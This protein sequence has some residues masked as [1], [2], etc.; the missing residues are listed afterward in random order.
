MRYTAEESALLQTLA[1]Q[2]SVAIKNGYLYRES[3][4]KSIIEEELA[5]A[6]RIQ[7]Q[8]LPQSLPSTPKLDLAALNV[9]T[10]EV[11][12]DYYDVV[13]LGNGEYLVVIADVAGKGVPAALL[14][15]MV[16]ASIRTQAQDRRPMGEL[17]CRLNRLVYDATPEDRFATCVLAHIGGDDPMLF[18]NAGHNFP[19]VLPAAGGWRY[20]EEGGIPLGVAP[21]FAYLE[22]SARLQDGDSLLLYTDGITDA[23]NLDG[24]DYGEERL[25]SLA[26]R[27]P[28]DYT[29][30]QIVQAVA[31][32]VSQFTGGAEQAD[33]ITLVALKTR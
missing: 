27:L 4:A 33:D 5:V 17:M 2:S 10:R 23:R 7:Q 19:I 8:F 21:E 3:L 29:A 28:R 13:G 20:L 11:G 26:G 32:D 16:Q 25:Q 30:K 9:Q 14:A 31:E 1:N 24:E 6:R 18:S 22:A 12:G 15:S